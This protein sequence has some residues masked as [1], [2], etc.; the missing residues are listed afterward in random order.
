M[1]DRIQSLW[2]G[3]RLSA[4]ERLCISSFL[5]NGHE[6]HLYVYEEPAGVLSGTVVQDATKIR[7]TTC[8]FT[9]YEHSSYAGFAN[10]FRYKLLL[11]KGGWFVATDTICLKPFD[12]PE[13]SV[14]ASQGIAG[15][16]LANV[17]AV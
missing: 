3:P 4:M 14:F 12:F 10:F 11:E 16:R 2:I 17:A 7:P 6:F 15:R 8:I 9:Y 13:G 1:Q 5:R